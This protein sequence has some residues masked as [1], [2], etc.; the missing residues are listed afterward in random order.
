MRVL[1]VNPN[2]YLSPPVPPV[3]LEQAAGELEQAGHEV[4]LLD[5]CFAG[6]PEAVLSSAVAEY[7]PEVAGFTVRNIDTVLYPS[8]EFFLEDIRGYV[9][10][11]KD[12]AP[13]PVIIGG[14]G[15]SAD[16]EG[17]CRYL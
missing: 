6:D 9:Q 10:A 7:A 12:V 1:L 3:G 8:N 5:L 2:R 17:I 11:V 13:V 4:S 15:V 14:A 16:P